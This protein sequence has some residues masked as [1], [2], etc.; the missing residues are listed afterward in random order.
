MFGW[1]I[2]AAIAGWLFHH[3]AFIS[4]LHFIILVDV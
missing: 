3:A 4:M 2:V 1:L